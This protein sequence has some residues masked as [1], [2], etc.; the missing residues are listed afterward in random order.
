[1]HERDREGLLIRRYSDSDEAT[2]AGAMVGWSL[3]AMPAFLTLYETSWWPGHCGR[4]EAMTFAVLANLMAVI[5]LGIWIWT[6]RQHR[7]RWHDQLDRH[8]AELMRLWEA[9]PEESYQSCQATLD[10][11]R[12]D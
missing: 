7:D 1:M 11:P 12:L 2:G 5:F 9:H 3:L 10:S 6:L 8:R 4:A